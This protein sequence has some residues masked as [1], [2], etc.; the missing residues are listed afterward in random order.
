MAALLISLLRAHWQKAAEA[1]L[2]LAVMGVIAV[3]HHELKND[4]ASLLTAAMV[5][6]ADQSRIA[7]LSKTLQDHNDAVT[8]LQTAQTKKEQA[9]EK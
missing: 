4:K 6:D 8:A 5:H 3:Q 9:V 1:I 7:Y 2:L